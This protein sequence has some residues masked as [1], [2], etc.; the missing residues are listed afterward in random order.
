[1]SPKVVAR[2][3]SG[4]EAGGGCTL[5]LGRPRGRLLLALLVDASIDGSGKGCSSSV[6]GGERDL[7]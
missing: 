5:V 6:R 2:S 1:L 4:D 7:K 3:S